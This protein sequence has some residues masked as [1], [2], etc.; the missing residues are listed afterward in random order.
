VRAQIVRRAAHRTHTEPVRNTRRT[1]DLGGLR[2]PIKVPEIGDLS[3]ARTEWC[4]TT[5]G[6]TGRSGDAG[7]P[8]GEVARRLGHSV[9]TLVGT[10]VGALD[11]DDTAA[12][13][14]IDSALGPSRARIGDVGSAQLASPPAPL[15]RTTATPGE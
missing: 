14:L 3:S 5:R 4:P 11:G 13:K 10:Y 15:P 6:E 1:G 2:G 9:A 7:G 12:N 8:L